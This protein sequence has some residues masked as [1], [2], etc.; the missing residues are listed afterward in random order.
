MRE[1]Y[2]ERVSEIVKDQVIIEKDIYIEQLQRQIITMQ[3]ELPKQYV[4]EINVLKAEND[5]L[6]Y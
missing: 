1:F 4:K 5:Q 6:L 2:L 3:Q